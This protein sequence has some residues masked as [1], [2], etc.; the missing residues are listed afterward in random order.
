MA[1]EKKKQDVAGVSSDESE[2]LKFWS[3]VLDGTEYAGQADKLELKGKLAPIF[4]LE[5]AHARKLACFGKIVRLEG[6]PMTE[7]VVKKIN[8]E[9]VTVDS[10]IRYFLRMEAIKPTL[11]TRG[12]RDQQEEVPVKKGEDILMPL[13]GNIKNVE[14][15][16]AAVAH[17][18]EVSI[19]GF[20]V[21]GQR[22]VNNKGNAMWDIE[23]MFHP[24]KLRREGR[25]LF[26][27]GNAV[28]DVSKQI[29]G[30]TSTGAQYTK[31]GEV[32]SSASASS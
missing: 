19:V 8:G 16:K 3:E 17:P 10:G 22:K 9:D 31:D 32:L 23:T 21:I 28:T 29:A 18:T 15:L 13:S 6:I 14:D 24:A 5:M 26:G 27:S 7:P 20:R 4:N 2:S 25:Y 30:T 11:G 12:D 1:T